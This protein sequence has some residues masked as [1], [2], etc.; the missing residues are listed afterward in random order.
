MVYKLCMIFLVGIY[1][2]LFPITRRAVRHPVFKKAPTKPDQN[3]SFSLKFPSIDYKKLSNN[4]QLAVHPQKNRVAFT[5]LTGDALFITSFDANGIGQKPKEYKLPFNSMPSNLAFSPDGKRI[6][7]T[8]FGSNKLLFF[9]YDNLENLL[10]EKEYQTGIS[11]SQVVFLPD[12]RSTIVLS[13]ASGDVELYIPYPKGT[14]SKRTNYPV[15]TEARSIS[16]HPSGKF[17]AVLHDDDSTTIPGWPHPKTV[18]TIFSIAETLLTSQYDYAVPFSSSALTFSPDGKKVA[19]A[20]DATENSGNKITVLSFDSS[21][22]KLSNHSE[23]LLAD[24][25]T[26]IQA[27]YNSEGTLCAALNKSGPEKGISFFNLS[28]QK[29]SSISYNGE[30]HSFT[31]STDNDFLIIAG[32]ANSSTG[33]LTVHKL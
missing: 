5:S 29:R 28:T 19:I 32:L 21:S 4:I 1:Q 17:L 2:P 12:N 30:P 31:F 11:P 13:Y 22:G 7:V 24:K 9:T 15:G 14:K 6:A 16:L 18:I 33:M 10:F 8:C 25:S 26:P 3:A 23:L 20:V 27:A